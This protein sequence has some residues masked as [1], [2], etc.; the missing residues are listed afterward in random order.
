LHMTSRPTK[1]NPLWSATKNLG[2]RGPK[3]RLAGDRGF[4]IGV[5]EDKKQKKKNKFSQKK[6]KK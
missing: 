3:K 1:N 6:K 2:W 5:A 4:S